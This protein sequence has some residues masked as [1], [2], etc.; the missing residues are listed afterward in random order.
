[1]GL[2]LAG[3]AQLPDQAAMDQNSRTRAGVQQQ[4]WE[5]TASLSAQALSRLDK[6]DWADLVSHA[7]ALHLPLKIKEVDQWLAM[8]QAQQTWLQSL[9]SYSVTRTQIRRNLDDSTVSG[10]NAGA[11]RVISSQE[12][13]WDALGAGAVWLRSQAGTQRSAASVLAAQAAAQMILLE[14]LDALHEASLATSI[15]P[16]LLQAL[17]QIDLA[18][19]LTQ[20]LEPLHLQ[21]PLAV[22]GWRDSL[23]EL[24]RQLRA[25]QVRGQM[26]RMALAHMLRLPDAKS[27]P[28]SWVAPSVVDAP[29]LN[30]TLALP[31]TTRIRHALEHNR[32]L[33][34]SDLELEALKLERISA[35]VGALP[36]VRLSY[37]RDH[38]TSTALAHS[39]WEEWG[40]SSSFQ[41]LSL[42]GA[43]QQARL[44]GHSQERETLR[45]HLLGYAV[46][47]Q[48]RLGYHMLGAARDRL[49]DAEVLA[50]SRAKQQEI[51]QT[52]LLFAE[53]DEIERARASAQWVMAR[54]GLLRSQ[55][56]VQR[57]W[58]QL[59]QASGHDP[60]PVAFLGAGGRI[61]ALALRQNWSQMLRGMVPAPTGAGT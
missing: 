43:W 7:L 25:E 47:E 57:Q 12:W 27:L 15:E 37:S 18:L 20:R 17:S 53:S 31:W 29:A 26:A 60:L 34:Q 38:D 48:I 9:P 3:C 5:Q 42:L 23:I 46:I 55:Q 24:R 11:R 45:Q 19:A 50:Y 14:C 41:F 21:D 6:P 1:M 8:D 32:D 61:D 54:A 59:A 49:T 58:L 16:D 40:A 30:R 35:W 33:R 44:T 56:D 22:L 28:V 13:S 4:T 2:A 52:R 36:G 10:S 51:R 39:R